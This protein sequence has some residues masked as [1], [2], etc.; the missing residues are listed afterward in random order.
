[1]QA[2]Q[3]HHYNA[4]SVL[5]QGRVLA[6][7]KHALPN[8]M[9]FDEKRYFDS[10]DQAVV[11]EVKGTHF[12]V[13]ICE[14]TRNPIAPRCTLKRQGSVSLVRSKWFAISYE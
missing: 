11:F 3:Q 2:N 13:N 8:D 9:V 4:V 7:H 5:H 14:D 6:Y 12:G 10:G 1:M